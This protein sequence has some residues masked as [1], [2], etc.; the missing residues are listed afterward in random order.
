M[1]TA[2]WVRNE[3]DQ[4][5]IAYEELHHEDAYT[6]QEVAQREHVSGHR[7]AALPQDFVGFGDVRA[8]RRTLR[9]HGQLGRIPAPH[10]LHEA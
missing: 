6:A 4:Q 8:H 7:V 9:Q 1:A 10:T 3:L 2:T 5:G